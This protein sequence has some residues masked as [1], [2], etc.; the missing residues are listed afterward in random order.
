MTSGEMGERSAGLEILSVAPSFGTGR[1]PF[2]G[3]EE[4]YQLGLSRAAAAA[5]IPWTIL[6][7]DTAT[8]TDGKVVTCLD[9]SSSQSI[10]S[11]LQRYL[12]TYPRFEGRMLG[13][14]VYEGD[15]ALAVALAQVAENHPSVR[16]FLNLFRAE[17]GLDAPLVRRKRHA[18]QR[19]LRDYSPGA[20]ASWFSRLGSIN[21]PENLRI[22][23]E[24]EA[25]ALLARSVGI[26]VRDVW[27]LHSAM[28]ER[29]RQDEDLAPH[30]QP[31]DLIRVLI[32]A[33]SSQ[34]H[35]P[36]VNDVVDVIERH[37]R[38]GG[39]NTVEW[40]MAGRFDDHPR[41]NTALRRLQRV[42]V[43]LAREDRPLD[44]EAYASM[45][46][47]VDA[48]WMP[49]VWP[50]RVQSS[51][52]ALDA[53]VLG[54]PVIAPAGT[55]PATSMQRWVSGAPTYGTNTEA[56]Q[57]FLRLPSLVGLLRSELIRQRAAIH[58]AYHPSA[59]VSWLSGCL[60]SRADAMNLNVTTSIS[61]E[62]WLKYAERQNRMDPA[63]AEH[64]EGRPRSSPGRLRSLAS[65]LRAVRRGFEERR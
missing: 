16:F 53:L 25:K 63:E 15:T 10:A 27:H 52:K 41:V 4:T 40:H 61:P 24:T 26:P 48:V 31:G 60:S 57:L 50:Y 29:Q 39:A 13:V 28:A 49:T 42:G 34:L 6:A 22:T 20:I 3:H 1:M 38:A 55:A 9:R 37:T 33:R 59:T 46:L 17:P 45:F 56:A 19:E 58:A 21:W 14:V 36:L 43:R 44:E 8:F 35:P 2:A 54:R 64:L 32:A 51:G 47:S 12:D 30:R 23:A 5:G 65:M 7:A 62:A 18:T 11:S